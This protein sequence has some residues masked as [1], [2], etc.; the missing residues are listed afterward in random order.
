MG[1]T[2][3]RI[4]Q[5]EAALPPFFQNVGLA[6]DSTQGGD[7]ASASPERSYYTDL[8]GPTAPALLDAI[9]IDGP[10]K[11]LAD[12]MALVRRLR[13]RLHRNGALFV[14]VD[15]IG[16]GPDAILAS[17]HSFGMAYFRGW[18]GDTMETVPLSLAGRVDFPAGMLLLRFQRRSYDPLLQAREFLREMAFVHALS[19][20]NDVVPELWYETDE[21]RG[22]HESERMIC[23]LAQDRHVGPEHRHVHFVT[24]LHA[25][26]RACTYVP[27]HVPV[28][29]CM[30]AFWRG[31]GR[32]DM[33]KRLL[34]T[35][36]TILQ[37]QVIES[38]SVDNVESIPAGPVS[39]PDFDVS[40]PLRILFLCHPESDFGADVLFDGMRRIL[41][42]D[43][44]VGYPWK[45]MLHGERFD[46]AVGY[47]CTFSWLDGPVSCLELAEALSEGRFDAILY[48]D[49]HGTLPQP[50]TRRLL[51]AAGDTPVFLL[52]MW[53]ECGALQDVIR[54]RDGIENVVGYFK[55]EML[56]GLDYGPD[57]WPLPFAY[58]DERFL[59]DFDGGERVGVFWAGKLIGGARRLQM[60]W[61]ATQVPVAGGWGTPYSQE[62]YVDLLHRH[63]VGL[64][65]YGNGFDTVRY[66]ELPAHG[67][68]LLSERPPILIPNNFEDGKHAVFFDHAGELL[69]KARY[70]LAHPDEAAVIAR[71]GRAHALAYHTGSARARQCLGVIQERL[72]AIG[73][74]SSGFSRP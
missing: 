74:R 6:L 56:P 58:P 55:R 37:A 33:E 16:P 62:V 30:A 46:E 43:H 22:F 53:D 15:E 18:Q 31:I 34:T 41:G 35:V 60:S 50:E 25:Y 9:V 23:L 67:V 52:D 66:W 70:Y 61:L 44:V 11:E 32:V 13:L 3:R 4:A 68:M 29:R 20:L 14:W 10:E 48:C 40:A 73:R 17:L 54:Q 72:R 12:W 59:S 64:S 65:F 28:Y 1:L 39:Y 45:P 42:A 36:E 63:A 21:D 47:P 26:N 57:A 27:T 2:A 5:L 7:I 49:V 8:L 69:D 19:V 38:R 71:A 51:N 24:A